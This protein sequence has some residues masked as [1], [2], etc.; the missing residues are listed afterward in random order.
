VQDVLV[1]ALPTDHAPAAAA[2]AAL[3]GEIG[4]ADLLHNRPGRFSA[5]VE[6]AVHKD[7]RVRLA[8]L[9]TILKLKPPGPYPG[10]SDVLASLAFLISNGGA[11]R[12]VVV[13]PRIGEARRL[14]GLL[15]AAGYDVEV[16][17]DGHVLNKL[18]FRQSDCELV[19]IST[20]LGKLAT[21]LTLKELRQDPRTGK[22]PV[23]LVG[24]PGAELEL[25][26]KNAVG[27]P[28]SM[29][30]VRPDNAKDMQFQV[31]LLLARLGR[32]ANSPE[33]RKAQTE[34]A[35]ALVVELAKQQGQLRDARRAQLADKK[36]EIPAELLAAGLY[37][38]TRIE[39]ALFLALHVP[40]LAPAAAE[41]LGQAGAPHAQ[42]A[43]VNLVN[44][45]TTNLE[46]RQ[47]AAKAFAES[48][49]R[50]GT[51]LTTV[52]IQQ[53]YNFYNNA[54]ATKAPE[55]EALAVILDAIEE[56]GG[57][58]KPVEPAAEDVPPPPAK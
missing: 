11:P 51:L 44:V 45:G 32:S 55:H 40:D 19:L 58:V 3:L 54:M 1:Q 49:R 50:W 12:A 21:S 17:N 46:D 27:D 13:D 38:F 10:S 18:A 33:V 39:K 28:L 48:V 43:L 36:V 2:A 25:A 24:S 41:A 23:A 9:E 6:A 34:K 37:D 35:L 20:D 5:L 29:E 52:E 14:G 26:K 22:L 8:A 31:N 4:T 15:S 30:M 16:T 56:K 53:Q 47:A 42:R 57:A 7:R